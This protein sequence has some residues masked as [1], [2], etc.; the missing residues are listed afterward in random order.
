MTEPSYPG[1]QPFLPPEDR[2]EILTAV[3]RILQ[4]GQFT[5][6]EHLRHFEADAAKMAGVSHAIA[7]N[8]GGAALELALEALDVEDCDVVVP[9][10]TFVASANSVVRAGGRPVFADL[11]LDDL[12]LTLATISAALTPNTKAVMLVHMFGLMSS[13]IPAIRTLCR[14]RGL[15]LIED[16]AHA[17]GAT[18]DGMPAGSLGLAGCFSYYATKILT[19]GEGGIVT[20]NDE[21]FAE[22]VRSIRDHGRKGDSPLFCY[23]GNNYRLPEIPAII[24]RVQQRRLAEILGHRRRIAKVYREMLGGAPD[25]KIVDPAPHEGHAYWR[26]VVLLSN[27]VDRAAVQK[28]LLERARARVTWMYEPLCHQQPYYAERSQY[29]ARLPVAESVVGRLIN[30]PTHMGVDEDGARLIACTLCTVVGELTG[31]A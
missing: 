5:Q 13:E 21:E 16:A 14:E 4:S 19:T 18:I 1:A 3:D 17:H 6:G 27:R 11:R 26:Y 20:T 9:T 15:A 22:R 10:Q 23:P 12:A 24:G 2:G 29:A 28:M 25:I 30:L 8:S 31:T 7:V